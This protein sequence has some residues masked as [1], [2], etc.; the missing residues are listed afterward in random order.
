MTLYRVLEETCEDGSELFY[1]QYKGRVL[2]HY[3][4]YGYDELLTRKFSKHADAVSFIEGEKK[5][6]AE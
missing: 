4:N 6:E 3:F 5:R 1:P 2:W